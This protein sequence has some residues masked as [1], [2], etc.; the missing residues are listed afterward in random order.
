MISPTSYRMGVFFT[1]LACCLAFSQ[2]SN[3]ATV[4][5]V[6]PGGSFTNIGSFDFDI[7]SPSGTLASTFYPTLPTGWV[8]GSSGS[9]VAYFD[10]AGGNSL[11]SGPIGS[12]NID[13]VLGGFNFFNQSS[14]A[15]DFIVTQV[16]TNYVVSAVPIPAAAWL[17]GSGLVGLV[18]LK[19]RKKA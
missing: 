7:L 8:D 1:I 19:R 14:Q 13:V 15:L 5:T 2:P 6:E 16:G 3:A 18:V 9:T 12:F 11:P 17:L 4:V 10:L